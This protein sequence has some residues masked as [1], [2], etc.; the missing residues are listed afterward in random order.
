MMGFGWGVRGYVLIIIA[1][2]LTLSFD[3]SSLLMVI[4]LLHFPSIYLVIEVY[5]RWILLQQKPRDLLIPLYR[6]NTTHLQVT[7]LLQL[8]SLILRIVFPY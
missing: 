8:L 2:D 7:V 4:E 5:G 1:F 6:L 3:Y